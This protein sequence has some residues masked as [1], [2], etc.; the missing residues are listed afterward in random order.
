MITLKPTFRYWLITNLMW[1]LIISLLFLSAFLFR[2]EWYFSYFL[3][4]V[5]M[6]MAMVSA[7]NFV[8]L[9]SISYIIDSE[10]LIV[11][12]GVFNRT[13]NYMELYRVYDY[14]KKQNIIE[15]AFGIMN[16]VI[17]SRDMSN[18]KVVLM[19]ITNNDSVIPFIR[20]RVETEK[21]RKR[22][23]EFNNPAG[24]AF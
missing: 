4:I 3:G 22:I 15:V 5:T 16:I 17:L 8:V 11:K 7:W 12:R 10:Q 18:P 23:F 24:T 14:Q 19:G 21:Q 13:T 6:L 9:R 20:D 2:L 1:I